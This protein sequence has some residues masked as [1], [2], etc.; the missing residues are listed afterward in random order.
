[1]VFH[2]AMWAFIW[3][4]F[5]V[6]GSIEAVWSDSLQPEG[7]APSQI[8]ASVCVWGEPGAR[9]HHGSRSSA[10][11]HTQ[12]HIAQLLCHPSACMETSTE[13]L[14]SAFLSCTNVIKATISPYCVI[15]SVVN[16]SPYTSASQLFSATPPRP[17]EEILCA[18]TN[19]PPRQRTA[20]SINTAVHNIVSLLTLKKTKKTG[21]R[22][23]TKKNNSHYF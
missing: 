14:L 4:Q 18:I 2:K 10:R 23:L 6:E 11:Q 16:L 5:S 7:G 8:I 12:T 19:S 20:P 22:Q 21:S 13:I 1:M 9:G 15:K 17:G 3:C